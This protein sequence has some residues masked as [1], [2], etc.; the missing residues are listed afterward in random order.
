MNS[1]KLSIDGEFA[2]RNHLAENNIMHVNRSRQLMLM[3]TWQY[4][5]YEA[6][7]SRSMHL[8]DDSAFPRSCFT[9]N[10]QT[11]RTISVTILVR[12]TDQQ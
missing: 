7:V 5:E 11:E 9:D 1:R 12:H 6:R 4:H 2:A 10:G 3:G 8:H